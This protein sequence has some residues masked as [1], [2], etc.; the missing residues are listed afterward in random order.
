MNTD[1]RS[2]TLREQRSLAQSQYDYVRRSI[3]YEPRGHRDMYAAVLRPRTE[4]VAAGEAHMG[5]LFLTHEGY[6]A[7]CGHATIA[8]GRFLVD[9]TDESIFRRRRDLEYDEGKGEVEVRLHAPVGLV[10]IRVPAMKADDGFYA[11]PTRPVTFLSVPTYAV[12]VDL[13]VSVPADLRWPELNGRESVSVDVGFGGVFC[14]V[15][16]ASALGF[17]ASLSRSNIAR[18]SV[19]AERLKKAM[20]SSATVR[21]RLVLPH[22][23]ES[24]RTVYGIMITDA[25]TEDDVPAAPDCEGGETGVYFYADGQIDRSP[26]GSVVQARV[27]LAVAK[28]QRRVGESWTYHSLVSRAQGGYKGGFVGKAVEEFTHDGVKG[29]RVEV[30][31]QPYY[32]G[33]ST[34]VSE[35]G[36]GVG[37]GFSFNALGER[38]GP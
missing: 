23:D 9:C 30:S 21:E 35:A 18:L 27:A 38:S 24:P 22:G 26:T 28:G 15:V 5:A 3:V 13:A 4:L 19:A 11:D 16:A 8:L 37:A 12:A 25:G 17:P 6:G 10:R 33:A 36:D 34:F 1:V 20:N 14:I 2:G 32:T 31:G 29:V 7:M